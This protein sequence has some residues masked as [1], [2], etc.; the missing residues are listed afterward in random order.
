MGYA[1]E[2]VTICLFWMQRIKMWNNA[3]TSGKW[4]WNYTNYYDMIL[5]FYRKGHC[6]QMLI[7][8]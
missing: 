4:K 2:H 3:K 1:C 6:A 7:G 5:N 8:N